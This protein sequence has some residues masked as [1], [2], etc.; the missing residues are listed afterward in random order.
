MVLKNGLQAGMFSR[1]S[2]SKHVFQYLKQGFHKIQTHGS[3]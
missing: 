3:L 2:V 1:S